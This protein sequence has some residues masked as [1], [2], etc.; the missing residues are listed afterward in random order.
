[1]LIRMPGAMRK[2]RRKRKGTVSRPAPQLV[3][4]H[5]G[6]KNTAS[7]ATTMNTHCP[8]ERLAPRRQP[9]AKRTLRRKRKSMVS[10]G[11]VALIEVAPYLVSERIPERVFLATGGRRP[12]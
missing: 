6:Q 3:W 5:R 2:L 1:M 4:R 12:P 8:K 7:A 10:P 11:S 9:D